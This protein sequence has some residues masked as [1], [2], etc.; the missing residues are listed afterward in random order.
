MRILHISTRLIIGGSQENTV[1]S[2]EGQSRLGHD[3]HLAFGPI[4]GPEGSMLA[5]VQA[6]RTTD[7][8]GITTHEVPSMIRALDP[9]ADVRC[10]FELRRLIRAIKP[11]VVHTHSSKAGVV[12]RAAA[13]DEGGKRGE[14]AVIHTIH[15]PPFH[16]Y[17][18]A[19][20]N[21]LYKGA[22]RFAARRC[23]MIAAVADT[24]TAQFRAADIGRDEQFITVRSGMEVGA[25]LNARPGETRAEVRRELGI[26]DDT[27]VIGTVAR[28]A[29]LKGHD[30]IIDAL[31]DDLRARE[32]LRLLWV[33]DGWW[34]RRLT[35]RLLQMNL[36]HKV[37]LTGLV[38]P[39]RVPAL[40][41]AMDVV[42]HPSYREGLPRVVPQALLCGVPVV[43]YD[44]DGTCEVCIDGKT[45]RLVRPGDLT[46]LREAVRWMLDDPARARITAETGRAMCR[47]MFSAQA[48]VE[49]LEALYAG[50]LKVARG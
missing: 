18:P 23:H 39:E 42:V 22:E 8:R 2:C 30:D 7:G 27:V 43:A 3:V 25:F 6:F 16:T 28:L 32:G 11:D 14:W 44:V 35:D 49:A 24:M 10:Y 47:D 21:L 41:R 34:T 12:G 45:G 9:R 13:W 33:G 15:G 36:R 17:E 5:R 20:K 50:A 38:P 31:C 29:E 19:W 37:V 40:I 46:G 48:M 1:L 4:Y 26:D